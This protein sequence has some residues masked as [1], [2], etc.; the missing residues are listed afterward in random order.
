VNIEDVVLALG[1]FFAEEIHPV[2]EIGFLGDE[3][4]SG[5]HAWLRATKTE[6]K[7][8]QTSAKQCTMRRLACATATDICLFPP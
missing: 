3:C 4:S 2:F 6:D 1:W 5:R 7:D 8:S